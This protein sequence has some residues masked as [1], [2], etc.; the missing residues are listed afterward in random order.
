MSTK[1]CNVLKNLALLVATLVFFVLCLEILLSLFWPHKITAKPYFHIQSFF[2]EYH[3]LMGWVNKPDYRDIVTVDKDHTFTVS[4]NSRGLRDR[5]YSYEKPR[6]LIRVLVFGDSF[7]WGFG[8]EDDEIFTEVLEQFDSDLEVINFGVSGYGTGQSLLYYTDEGYKYAHDIVIYAFYSNDTGELASSI[9]YGYPK[10]FFIPD[11]EP[12][13]VT[14]VPVPRTEE[15]E[16]KLYGNPSSTFG[17][18]KKFLRRNTHTY[19]FIVGRLNSVPWLRALFLKLGLAE[20]Y[21][22][23]YGEKVPLYHIR[24]IDRQWHLFFRLVE[25]FRTVV[26]E[27]GAMFVLLHIPIQEPS[28]GMSCGYEDVSESDWK[29][30]DMIRRTLQRFAVQQRIHFIDMLAPIREAQARGISC[31]NPLARDIHLNAEGHRLV[32]EKLF[33]WLTGQTDMTSQG[34]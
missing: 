3:P 4:H 7:V 12:L 29:T 2:C 11:S 8:V 21:K 17:R 14:N 25:E 31:Y 5:N 10:P 19:Q 34:D 27:N 16:R 33:Q 13:T 26:E 9:N 22:R 6:E 24:E 28:Q 30:N 32:A 1:Q 18:L 20:D 15:S 23:T